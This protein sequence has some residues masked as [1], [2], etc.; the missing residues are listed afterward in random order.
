[1]QIT[2]SLIATTVALYT[3][4]VLGETVKIAYTSNGDFHQEDIEAERLTKLKHPGVLTDIQNTANCVLWSHHPNHPP[5]YQVKRGTNIIIPPKQLD[6][7]YCYEPNGA[8]VN[9]VW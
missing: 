9:Y 6:Y 1:M 7:I 5:D 2:K 4:V 8:W 3:S